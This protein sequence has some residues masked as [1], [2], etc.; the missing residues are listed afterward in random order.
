MRLVRVIEN[1][2]A[3]VERRGQ[4]KALQT[5]EDG[6]LLLHQILDVLVRM[7]K[8]CRV[9]EEVVLLLDDFRRV[10]GVLDD[11]RS[12]IIVQLAI[13]AL[14]LHTKSDVDSIAL[15]HGRPNL[16]IPFWKHVGRPLH[17]VSVAPDGERYNGVHPKAPHVLVELALRV[18]VF[19]QLLAEAHLN[20]PIQQLWA[21]PPEPIKGRDCFHIAISL[22]CMCEHE[23][24][25]QSMQ[26]V[27]FKVLQK[28]HVDPLEILVRKWCWHRKLD[29]PENLL[30]HLVVRVHGVEQRVHHF[31][32]FRNSPNRNFDL[33]LFDRFQDR[34]AHELLH[35]QSMQVIRKVRKHGAALRR[36]RLRQAVLVH[37]IIDGV[38][39]VV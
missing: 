15:S 4:D 7:G 22:S 31:P 19:L 25:R 37:K 29:V 23:E 33:A 36:H 39:A 6:R 1:R 30:M 24:A 12:E 8:G 28:G 34:T 35:R 10:L 26:V 38:V 16:L 17:G 3:G 13:D 21:D 5:V 20:V 14:N 18:Q 9:D 27:G 32:V 11:H 2:T